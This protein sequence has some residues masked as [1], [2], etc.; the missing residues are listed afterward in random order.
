MSGAI[1]PLLYIPLH[2]GSLIKHRDDFIFIKYCLDTKTDISGSQ[3]TE[4]LKNVH[5]LSTIKSY[6]LRQAK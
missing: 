3:I 4:K 2:A 6:S 5:G 1:P